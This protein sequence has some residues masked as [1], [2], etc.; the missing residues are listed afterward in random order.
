MRNFIVLFSE[1]EGTTPVMQLLDQFSGVSVV[2]QVDQK[3]W[4]PFD[5]HNC[6]PMPVR[7]L[8][9]C[10]RVLYGPQ[11]V[12]IDAVNRIYGTTANL[13]LA[14]VVPKT[15]VG[16]KMRFRPPRRNPFG[17]LGTGRAGTPL[18][19]LG[20][21]M[22]TRAFERRM[23]ALFAELDVTALIAVR[24]DLLRWALSKYHGDGTGTPGHLQFKLAAGRIQRSDIG[25]FD[26]DLG[27]LRAIIDTCRA[28]HD[29]KRRLRDDLEAAGVR[30]GILRYEEFLTDAETYFSDLLAALDVHTSP[31]EVAEVLAR[32]TSFE[33]VH[34]DD[35]S[36]IV[37]N[38]DEVIAAFGDA[39]V[40]W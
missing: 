21:A 32:G 28:D 34:S 26:A 3:G 8:V 35:I 12:D 37:E 22:E 25:K 33:K 13:P 19:V 27:R 38:P 6:G 36:E 5:V 31:A 16:F 17:R 11:P 1:K 39:F 23:L 40:R 2:H 24:Q 10:L 18:R 30:T 29:R 7:S 14:P 9:R 4:E 15:A 20:R